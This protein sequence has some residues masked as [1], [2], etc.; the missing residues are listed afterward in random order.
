MMSEPT[1]KIA[2]LRNYKEDFINISFVSVDSKLICHACDA[3]MTNHS[4]NKIKLKQLVNILRIKR[5]YILSN[6]P[7]CEE[8]K[9]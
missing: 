7:T 3:F 6:N 2:K 9:C 5:K 8:Y 4:T 1:A